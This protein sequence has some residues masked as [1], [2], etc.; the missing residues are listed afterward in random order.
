MCMRVHT[1][2]HTQA[3]A[4]THTYTHMQTHTDT[5]TH[6]AKSAPMCMHHAKYWEEE[7]TQQAYTQPHHNP[8]SVDT[9]APGSCRA[10]RRD[11]A[12]YCMRDLHAAQHADHTAADL[13]QVS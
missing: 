3:H 6:T 5:Q 1:H 2:A 7:L 4:H 12:A 13:A 8:T 9:H 11:A 10:A